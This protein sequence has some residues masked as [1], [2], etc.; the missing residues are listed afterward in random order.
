MWWTAK[1]FEV[2]THLHNNH[3]L[4]KSKCIHF[5]NWKIIDWSMNMWHK[6]AR[7]TISVRSNVALV[8]LYTILNVDRSVMRRKKQVVWWEEST[9]DWHH[10]ERKKFWH[11]V[12]SGTFKNCG[13]KIPLVEYFRGTT[14]SCGFFLIQLYCDSFCVSFLGT[15]WS[16]EKQNRKVHGHFQFTTFVEYHLCWIKASC[17][18]AQPPV[19]E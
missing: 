16:E 6:S 14:E 13:I 3:E 11:F 17:N 9:F 19:D 10:N 12:T 2:Q 1:L 15:T 5:P 18:S 4:W 8:D 7:W